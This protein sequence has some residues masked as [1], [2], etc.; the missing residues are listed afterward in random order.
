MKMDID[1]I[2]SVLLELEELPLDIY[3]T[4]DL[5]KSIKKY[6]IKS[7]EY[8]IIKLEEAGYIRAGIARTLSGDVEVYCISDIT[9]SGHQFLEKIR[10]NQVWQKTK[11]VAGSIGTRALDLIAQI[12]TG[13]LTELVNKHLTGQI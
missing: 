7:V 1:C 6:G 2:R 11:N 12:A 9:F 10:D 3:T 8:S 4:E 13:V 5:T